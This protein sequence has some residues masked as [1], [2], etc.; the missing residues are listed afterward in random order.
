MQR[1]HKIL[2]GFA[3]EGEGG[4]GISFLIL[5]YRLH[6]QVSLENARGVS[7]LGTPLFPW[8]SPQPQLTALPRLSGPGMCSMST[9]EWAKKHSKEMRF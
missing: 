6:H 1:W 4:L 5:P 9:K 7:G 2:Q 8:S 3:V